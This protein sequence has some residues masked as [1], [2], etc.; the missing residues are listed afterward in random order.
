MERKDMTEQTTYLT[1]IQ[2][3]DIDASIR[4]LKNLVVELEKGGEPVSP[5]LDQIRMVRPTSTSTFTFI[6]VFKFKQL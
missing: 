3:A 2:K 1:P 6:D 4:K 5:D